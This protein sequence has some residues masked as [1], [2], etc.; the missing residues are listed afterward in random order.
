MTLDLMTYRPAGDKR[1]SDFFN[2]YRV[3]IFERRK[4]SGLE[5]LLDRM[6]G[7]VVQVEH[8]DAMAYLE[9][10]YFMTPYRFSCARLNDTHKI[11]FLENTPEMPRLIVLELLSTS[12][13][14][15]VTR[16]NML[17][18]MARAKP[19]ARYIGEI[20]ATKDKD[21]T[22]KILES[23]E[24]RFHDPQEEEN[25]FFANE[26]FTFTVPSDF[27]GNRVGY[28]DFDLSDIDGMGAGEKIGL[29][30]EE[31]RRLA[32]ADQK[33]KDSDIGKLLLG[34][35]HMATRILAA[36]ARTRSSSS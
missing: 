5:D 30:D 25:G 15:D 14:D 17:Y 19:N 35:D 6:R 10:L 21:E 24:I 26:H 29:T 16:L 23:H 34:L 7:I 3:K 1:S 27:T 4:S 20:F 2:E 32:A 33:T 18:P 8:G 31:A 13:N 9:E 36:S 11:Y 28:T 12:Y 22:R